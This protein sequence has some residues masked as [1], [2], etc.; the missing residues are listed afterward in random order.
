MNVLQLLGGCVPTDENGNAIDPTSFTQIPLNRRISVTVNGT[1]Y[2]FDSLYFF[3]RMVGNVYQKGLAFYDNLWK[4]IGTYNN[5]HTNISLT[6]YGLTNPTT[7]ISFTFQEMMTIISQLNTQNYHIKILSTDN[8]P[9]MSSDQRNAF[10]IHNFYFLD[11]EDARFVDSKIEENF[12]MGKFLKATLMPNHFKL[13]DFYIR[14]FM[15]EVF[16]GEIYVGMFDDLDGKGS[17]IITYN[18]L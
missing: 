17:W 1:E 16:I 11:N 2:C 6:F 7:N 14:N 13:Y 12:G 3:G 9:N 10:L 15:P 5:P 8:F 18:T 4:E